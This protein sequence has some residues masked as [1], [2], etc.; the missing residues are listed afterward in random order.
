MTPCWIDRGFVIDASPTSQLVLEKQVASLGLQPVPLLSLLDLAE[1]RPTEADILFLANPKQR[2][3]TDQLPGCILPDLR[4][5]ASVVILPAHLAMQPDAACT[6]EFIPMPVLRRD[7]LNRLNRMSAPDMPEIEDE[8][9]S[10]A[11]GVPT[12]TAA[13]EKAN[14]IPGRAMRVL[15]AED[16]KTNRLVLSK[17][18]KSLDIDLVLAGDGAQAI[19]FY[20]V[21]VP[22]IFFADISM[23]VMDGKDAARQIR[24]IEEEEGRERVPIVA[25][26]AHAMEGDK[27]EIL[28]SGIDHYLTKPL[29]KAALVGFIQEA[30]PHDVRPPVAE[31]NL[32]V[33]TAA[34]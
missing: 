20:K 1:A 15:A 32:Q 22:D 5:A 31:D 14:P 7:L 29:K 4:A 13:L 30:A 27:D 34:Q 18:L 23:P 19:E 9:P 28:A 3:D 2:T 11:G 17:M 21:Q 16:N 8:E 6:P 26:T 33:S 12:Q 24:H 25:M 10:V